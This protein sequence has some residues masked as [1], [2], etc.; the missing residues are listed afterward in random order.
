VRASC[1]HLLLCGHSVN[2]VMS[3][4]L[5]PLHLDQPPKSKPIAPFMG[6]NDEDYLVM[7]GQVH[8]VSGMG[9]DLGVRGRHVGPRAA[10]GRRHR[11]PDRSAERGPS[12]IH[13]KVMRY[14]RECWRWPR[15]T[16]GGL[17]G[18]VGAGPKGRASPEMRPGSHH[19]DWAATPQAAPQSLVKTPESYC[20][21]A[22]S[23]QK[24]A[25][26]LVTFRHGRSSGRCRRGTRPSWLPTCPV[27]PRQTRCPCPDS[28][29]TS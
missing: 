11:M 4:V 8:G 3:A 25:N 21:V 16:H 29:Q 2:E 14:P 24:S 17:T 20:T 7:P 13:R 12:G 27:R 22:R 6:C 26:E 1:W 10:P 15:C 28:R 19:D 9:D 23:Y 5:G 18:R